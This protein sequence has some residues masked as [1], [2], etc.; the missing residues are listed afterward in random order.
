MKKVLIHFLILLILPTVVRSQGINDNIEKGQSNTGF[1]SGEV[2]SPFKKAAKDSTQQ[3]LNVPK[4][5]HQWH[6]SELLGEVIP[7]NA[8]TLQYQFQ[9]WHGTDGMNGEYNYLGNMGAPRETRIF[10][11]REALPK[12]DFLK[13]YD[14][15]ITPTDKFF[16]TDTKSP[17]TNLSYHSSGDKITGDDRFR[18]YFA[19]NAG[20]KFGAGFLF[21]YLYGR[22]RY[23]NQ[24]TAYTD[25][26]LYSYYRSDKYNF[27]MLASR[28]HMKHTENGGI[29]DDTYI[30]NPEKTESG[31]KNFGTNDIP[32]NLQ[33]TWNRN[34]VYSAFFTHN[35]NIGFYREVPVESDSLT[36]ASNNPAEGSDSIATTK[37]TQANKS[38]ELT[39]NDT[40]ST[41]NSE[42]KKEFV[43]V[44]R[45]TH[46]FKINSD[47]R[48]FINYQQ[49]KN[50]YADTFL[51]YDS[52]DKTRNLNIKNTLAISL[53]EGFNK[54]A[55][56][57]IT[58]YATYDY[59][60][61]TLPDTLPTGPIETLAR[62][63][64]YTLNVGGI[65][66]R[67]KG[68]LLNYKLRGEAS[69]A[70]E[71]IGAFLME[72]DARLKFKLWKDDAY[73]NA[74]AFIKNSNPS[75]YYRHYHSEHYWWD[76][77]LDKEFRSR[78][79]ASVDIERW[80]TKLSAGVETVKNYTYLANKSVPNAA[81]DGYLNRITVAQESE[82]IQVFSA[83]LQQKLKA[84]VFHLDTEVTYQNTSNKE[85]LP[86][87][88]L[89]AY[90]NFYVKFKIA[91]VLNTELGADARYFTSYYA[92]DYSP[93]LGQFYQQN[94][95]DKIEIGNYPIVNIYANFLLKETRFY[96]MYHH[97]NEGTGNRQYFLAPHYPISPKAIWIGLSWN[98][99]N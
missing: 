35:Y 63:S 26:S 29:I 42:Y 95:G 45:F 84:G 90:A 37:N 15:F 13:P 99:Y 67:E 74:K 40:L 34:E 57:G 33:K 6:I 72:G 58:A 22:G 18:A 76:K 3:M 71:D 49:P 4:E 1:G 23:D 69:I 41:Q 70:G 66:Q 19:T 44:T 54:W 10:F 88:E 91:N 83:T 36:D 46:T 30:T 16:F 2:Y 8:D 24:S 21:D 82:N 5:I 60:R 93:A 80:G 31:S 59:N 86:L 7:I 17:Y 50:F 51:K 68:K 53:L 62:V 64:E 94:P 85:V 87:P 79:E 56:A 97:I 47:E 98:F 27:Y 75:F 12:F 77:N 11:N 96:A 61:Y 32:V 89:N 48:S 38:D 39:A 20:K 14:Y 25:F 73:F 28:Y 78:V 52:L 55:V 65:L 81:G 92:P 9:N 43:P